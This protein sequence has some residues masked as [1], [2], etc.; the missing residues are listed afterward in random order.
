MVDTAVAPVPAPTPPRGHR[1]WR[2]LWFIAPLLFLLVLVA[3]R[4]VYWRTSIA[5]HP[6][7]VVGAG[8]AAL[9]QPTSVAPTPTGLRSTAATGTEQLFEFPLKNDGIHALEINGVTAAD[10]AVVGVQWAANF[11]KDGR[12]VPS[13]TH[14]LPVRVPGHAV[15]NLQLRVRQP[16]CTKGTARFLS[17]VVTIHWHAMV[18]PHATRL[19]L[20]PGRPHRIALCAG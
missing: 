7:R 3:S 14:A 16:A 17:A 15:V 11:V 4:V 6:L 18:S 12:R 19:N 1:W 10:D 9:G 8:A 20:L 13:A 2:T 5:Y